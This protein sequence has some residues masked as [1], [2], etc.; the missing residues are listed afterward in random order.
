[1]L[2]LNMTQKIQKKTK[3]KPH[4]NVQYILISG[5]MNIFKSVINLK[6]FTPFLLLL[7]LYVFLHK[8]LS[9][10]YARTR[11]IQKDY[12]CMFFLTITMTICT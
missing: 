4:T 12:N 8:I 9:F 3:F 5:F 10:K 2:N 7:L 1:M 6:H 11:I